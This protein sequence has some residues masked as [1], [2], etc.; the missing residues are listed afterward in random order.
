ML[1][2]RNYGTFE[3]LFFNLFKIFVREL[4]SDGARL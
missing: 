4:G 1:F 2:Y 3:L